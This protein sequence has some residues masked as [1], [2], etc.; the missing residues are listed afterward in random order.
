MTEAPFIHVT[1]MDESPGGSF[2]LSPDSR[3]RSSQ[4][5][6]TSGGP[7]YDSRHTSP[8]KRQKCH[9]SAGPSSAGS[10]SPD[11]QLYLSPFVSC[12]PSPLSAGGACNPLPADM[13]AMEL[14]DGY[15]SRS[16]TCLSTQDPDEDG[17]IGKTPIIIGTE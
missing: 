15:S 4:T 11:Q 3:K 12:P 2:I 1:P 8:G 17:S 13:D 5:V 14:T 10:S 16:P 6:L 7:M 9:P